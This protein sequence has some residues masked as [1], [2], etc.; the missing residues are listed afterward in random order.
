MIRL[1]KRIRFYIPAMVML[2]GLFLPVTTSAQ[3][4]AV[5]YGK[6]SD[7]RNRPLELVN[8]SMMGVPGGTTSDSQGKYELAIPADSTVIVA[9]SILGYAIEFD[10]L[11]IAR[12]Q[13]V[14]L[15]VS[16]TD[17]SF[18]LGPVD[19]TANFDRA[20]GIIR[21]DPRTSALLPTPGG[22]E[23]LVKLIGMGVSSGNE[24]SSTYSVRGGNFDENIVYANDIE[25]YRPFLIRSGQQE[26]L[27]FL[28]S[29][30]VNSVSFSSGGFEARYGDKMSSVLDVQYKRP[31]SLCGD[32]QVSMLGANVHVEGTGP[33][34]L[35]TFLSGFRYKSTQYL[36]NAMETKGEYKPSFLD[37]QNYFTWK[38]SETSELSVLGYMSSNR[39][40]LVPETRETTYGTVNQAYRLT[41]YFDGS[42]TDKFTT[43]LGGLKFQQSPR[44]GLLLKYIVSAYSSL[45]DE[46]YDIQ[47][48]YWIG[49]LE[50]D[51]GSDEYGEVAE[52]LGVGTY[53]DHAR[54]YLD[55]RV[56]SAEH[57]GLLEKENYYLQWGVKAQNEQISDKIWQWNYID[58]SGYSLPHGTD[59]VGYTI[60]SAQDYQNLEISDVLISR[61]SLNSMR[62]SGFVQ[63]GWEWHSDSIRYNVIGGIRASYWDVNKDLIVSPR[64]AISMKPNWKEDYLFRFATGWYQQ[65]PFYRELRDMEGNLHTDLK[66]QKSIHFVAG[67]EHTDSMWNRP[68]R[69]VGEVYY[70]ALSDL[71]PYVVDNVHIRY[72]P[73]YRSHGYAVG[74][75]FKMNGQFVPDAESWVSV[76]IMQTREDIEG[77]YYY[78]YYNSDG[79]TIRPNTIN[80]IAVD[81]L[82]IEPGYIPRPTDQRVNVSLF[83]QDYLP[84]NP[85]YKMHLSL[86]FGT[87]LPFGPPD[88]DKYK[89][90]L[91]MSPYRRVDIG[92]SKQIVGYLDPDK[93]AKVRKN[94]KFIRN[95]WLSL[96]V[97]NLLNINNTVS[98]IWVTDVENNRYAVPNYLTKRQLNL[99]LLVEF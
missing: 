54:N 94:L 88:S 85:S 34:G 84:K 61:L 56:I 22:I 90:T 59:S 33:K 43:F 66:A 4:K 13:R 97:F 69:M 16:L 37:W 9:F 64:A 3:N 30:L 42:E 19:V 6:V 79:D 77:D 57:K 50:S 48:Q 11:K 58:S 18:I 68:F 81:S 92:F 14:E 21:L 20:G 78:I 91:R 31:D 38:L 96:E 67:F 53:L 82:R 25:I 1:S 95:A 23:T 2:A 52:N 51:M 60:P 36:L 44:K 80:N 71:I 45:E 32:A 49:L 10:T 86:V 65:P 5:V 29:S 72:L 47:G 28:N 17:K 15:N 74:V 55:T 26:G 63:N 12:G 40:N 7:D 24:L 35:M 99:K 46:T 93:P 27:S 98:Y 41:I 39:Y 89:Q 62:Y 87:K 70:K 8:I 83:F 75:D 73:E 76:S